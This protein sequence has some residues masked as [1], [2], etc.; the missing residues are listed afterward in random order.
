MR[1]LNFTQL[2]FQLLDRLLIYSHEVN[3]KSDFF[4]EIYPYIIKKFQKKLIEYVSF[5]CSVQFLR[6]HRFFFWLG[7]VDGG[8]FSGRESHI[9]GWWSPKRK[10]LMQSHAFKKIFVCVHVNRLF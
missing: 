10:Q 4:P 9:F 8:L 5:L 1:E 2:L 6:S 7:W 3:R